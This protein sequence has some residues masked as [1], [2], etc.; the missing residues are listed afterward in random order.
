MSNFGIGIISCSIERC[1]Y[2][3]YSNSFQQWSCYW[4]VIVVTSHFP[5]KNS[6]LFK[7][8]HGGKHL[9]RVE[10]IS[11]ENDS[12]YGSLVQF[13][14]LFVHKLHSGRYGQREPNSH[15]IRDRVS[16]FHNQI[17][18]WNLQS[19]VLRLSILN[20]IDWQIIHRRHTLLLSLLWL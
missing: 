16:Q 6:T 3:N 17:H 7:C 8:V 18:F 2:A 12:R 15:Q 13:G 20:L 9:L 5:L 19:W 14:N 11:T 1:M 4:F 10:T